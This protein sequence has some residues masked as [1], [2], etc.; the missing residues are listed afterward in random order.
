MTIKGKVVKEDLEGGIW[1]LEADD[2]N[3]YQ[4]NGGDS[5]LLKNGQRA[6]VTGEVDRN[7]MGIGMMGEIF[8][9]KSYQLE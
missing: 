4:L 1:I 8:K 2:G 3:R 7:A 6:A 9:V 5:K